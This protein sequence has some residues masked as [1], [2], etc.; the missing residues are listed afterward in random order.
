ML[1]KYKNKTIKF[2]A[3]ILMTVMLFTNIAGVHAATVFRSYN[4]SGTAAS[5]GGKYTKMD[6]LE[7]I[8][9]NYVKVVVNTSGG[10]KF[11]LRLM[12]TYD[13]LSNRKILAEKKGLVAKGNSYTIYFIPQ[14]GTCPSSNSNDCV[15]VPVVSQ[16]SDSSNVVSF[17]DVLYGIEIYNGSIFGGTVSI[18][19]TYS[20]INY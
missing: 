3:F 7:G 4:Y 20:F 2:M 13:W 6:Y 8:S 19:G 10:D 15:K 17:Y 9:S 11:D 18:S 5:W 1:K 14:N 16:I 12:Y